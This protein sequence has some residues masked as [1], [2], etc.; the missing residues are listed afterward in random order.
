MGFCLYFPSFSSWRGTPGVYVLDIYVAASERGTGLAQR[1]MKSTAS[2]AGAEGAA[3]V[4]LS[5]SRGN[6]AAQRFY[7][8]LGLHHSE[9]E[10]IYMALGPAFQ[11]LKGRVEP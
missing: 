11:S 10:C 9:Q 7:A 6:A 3:F 8:N 4:R 5:V 1:L 2:E